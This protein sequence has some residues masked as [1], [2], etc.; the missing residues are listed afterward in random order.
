MTTRNRPT[1]MPTASWAYLTLG[2]VSQALLLQYSSS[3]VILHLARQ[4]I[5]LFLKAAIEAAGQR[6]DRLAHNLDSLFIEYRRDYPN[7]SFHFEIPKRFH[8]D[9][10]R[11]LFPE[12]IELIHA[13]LDQ[14]HRFAADRRGN[15]F[16]I[17]EVFDPIVMH[18]E[19][20]ELR[21]ALGILEWCE[22]RPYL[23]IQNAP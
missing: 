4:G 20:E 14:R 5:E 13:T 3:R 12:T 18:K 1:G 23:Q 8:V 15:S 2:G 11:D 7:L 16:A 9:L 22:L 6:P 17:P 19:V 10:N 21:R